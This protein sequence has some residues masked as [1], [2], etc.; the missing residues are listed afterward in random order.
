[1][2]HFAM[3]FPG[4]GSQYL[5]MLSEIAQDFPQIKETFDLASHILNYDLWQLTQKGPE[6]QLNQTE[7]TQPAL[8]TASIA[9]WQVWQS[10]EGSMPKFLAGHSVGEYSALVCAKALSFKDAVSL[11][12]ERGK[13]MQQAVKEGEGAMA[14]ILG[15]EDETVISLC[16]SAAQS[17]V[18]SP[19]AFN[20]L[21]QVVVSGESK[22]VERLIEL[23][24]KEGARLA[25]KIP[26]SVPSHCFLMRPAA[27]Q[28]KEKLDKVQINSPLIPVIFNVDAKAHQ[29]ASSIRQAL[30]EQLYLPVRWVQSIQ[31]IL[32]QDIHTFIECGPNKVLTGLNKRI[33]KQIHTF[34]IEKLSLLNKALD[35][36]KTC[37]LFY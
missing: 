13:L 20:S 14:A 25:K 21:G 35:H 32:S 29:E 19:S 16:Q 4:Q 11:V 36:I 28:L 17:A 24:E 5:G 9:L 3:V 10:L 34:S 1:M 27:L 23:A 30:I 8:L 37:S 6:E 12:S 18:L 7:Y 26:V 2:N 33:S 22:A 15:L 31:A